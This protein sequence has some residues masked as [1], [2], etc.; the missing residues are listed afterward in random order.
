MTQAIRA[1]RESRSMTISMIG[2]LFMGVAGVVAGL[3][4]NSS[5]IM[6]DGLFST[7]GL[8]SALVGLLISR[9]LNKSPD[10]FRPL[11]YATEESLFTTFRALTV[12][13]LI[14]FAVASSGM[15]IYAYIAHGKASELIFGP[16]F[17]YF[18]I[19][20]LACFLLWLVHYRSW[21]ATGRRSDILRLEAKAAV[22]DGLMTGIAGAGLIGIYFFQDGIL[23]SIAPVGDSLIVLVL[24][25]AAIG[26]FWKDFVSGLGELARATARPETIATARRAMR[27]FL[28][29]LPGEVKDFTV[30]KAGRSYLICIYYMPQEPVSARE[31]DEVQKG[32]TDA[33]QQ[34][35][36]GAE[37]MVL[38]SE[39][40]R[41]E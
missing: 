5:A 1:A 26:Q 24:C 14:L 30:M 13:G 34:D 22:F 18:V 21:V 36:E 6:M 32:L 40:S 41:A 15:T 20:M 29:A 27:P 28:A 38:V 33:V 10:K 3:M 19:I 17:I 7:I 37:V 9:R 16:V 4:A 12:L 8:I 25:V 39:R 23:A 31:V 2:N 11:G 35:L